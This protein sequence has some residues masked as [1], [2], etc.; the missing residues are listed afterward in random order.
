MEPYLFFSFFY[1][2]MTFYD[3]IV[4]PVRRKK[5]NLLR[6]KWMPQNGAHLHLH[7]WWMAIAHGYGFTSI[8][9]VS[10]PVRLVDVS[11]VFRLLNR[12]FGKISSHFELFVGIAWTHSHSVVS[13]GV[14]PWIW[15]TKVLDRHCS[16]II[17]VLE[18]ALYF[19]YYTEHEL[20]LRNH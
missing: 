3:H 10:L 13:N 19:A 11:L 18:V 6:L 17:W 20:E 2:W 14:K 1:L 5:G 16:H 4:F 15:W 12:C 7:R 9:K 8:L